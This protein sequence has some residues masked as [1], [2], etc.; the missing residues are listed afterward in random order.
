MIFL[1]SQ[2]ELWKYLVETNSIS[3]IAP[4]L[5]DDPYKIVV[6]EDIFFKTIEFL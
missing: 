5:P 2:D 4:I 1:I 3:L 6:N